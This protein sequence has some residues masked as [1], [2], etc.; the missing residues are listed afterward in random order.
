M[1][2]KVQ[3]KIL[4]MCLIP[5]LFISIVLSTTAINN[6][7]VL[8]RNDTKEKLEVLAKTVNLTFDTNDNEG[9]MKKLDELAKEY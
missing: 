9:S 1:K 4:L 2:M 3:T 7:R 6:A 5:M 8:A